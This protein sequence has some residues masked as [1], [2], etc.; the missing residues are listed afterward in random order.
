MNKRIVFRNMDHSDVMQEYANGQLERV[1][2]F[3]KDDRGP[4][5]LISILNQVGFIVTI[6][7]NYTSKVLIII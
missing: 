7:L 3:L 6:A 5:L 1:I 2:E 4:V